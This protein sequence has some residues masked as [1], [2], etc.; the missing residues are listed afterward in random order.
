MTNALFPMSTACDG[1]MRPPP[2]RVLLSGQDREGDKGAQTS[3]DKPI[4]QRGTTGYNRQRRET[5]VITWSWS[6]RPITGLPPL[7]GTPY[8]SKT[9]ARLHCT[10]VPIR[11][12]YASPS[13]AK[14]PLIVPWGPGPF[15]RSFYHKTYAKRGTHS[16]EDQQ[17]S[18]SQS[19]SQH[20]HNIHAADLTS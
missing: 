3:R 10:S 13:L 9:I 15:Q 11:L 16:T 7:R 4:R 17:W 5:H 6:V 8:Y 14:T 2:R 18:T 20:T 12:Y 1:G 19:T